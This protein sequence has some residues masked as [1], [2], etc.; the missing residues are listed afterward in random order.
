MNDVKLVFMLPLS[1]WPFC[2]NNIYVFA[3]SALCT[4]PLAE[5]RLDNNYDKTNKYPLL[6]ET[7]KIL[8]T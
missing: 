3:F 8:N 2:Q 5:Y 4:N 6:L 7:Y 1:H